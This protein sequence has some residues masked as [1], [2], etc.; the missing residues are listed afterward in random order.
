MS[1]WFT[2]FKLTGQ[3]DFIRKA[4]FVLTDY[5]LYALISWLQAP[6]CQHKPVFVIKSVQTDI[7]NANGMYVKKNILV[8]LDLKPRLAQTLLYRKPKFSIVNLN[9]KKSHILTVRSTILWIVTLNSHK[10][11]NSIYLQV[12]TYST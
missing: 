10:I 12:R 2:A 3:Y 7:S 5:V 11:P 6:E 9:E 1:I 8:K 4:E